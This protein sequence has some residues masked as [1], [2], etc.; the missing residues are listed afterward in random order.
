M[1]MPCASCTETVR[2]G[3][4]NGR[5]QLRMSPDIVATV[6]SGLGGSDDGGKESGWNGN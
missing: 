3:R 2:A 1:D 6:R 5:R 4:T